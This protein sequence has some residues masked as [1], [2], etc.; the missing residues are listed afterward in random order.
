MLVQG[1]WAQGGDHE[2]GSLEAEAQGFVVAQWSYQVWSKHQ[3]ATERQQAATAGLAWQRWERLLAPASRKGE[4]ELSSHYRRPQPRPAPPRLPR[5]VLA[6]SALSSVAGWKTQQNDFKINY[7]PGQHPSIVLYEVRWSRGT[8]R[9]IWRTCSNNSTQ[10]AEVSCLENCFKTVPSVSCSI[11]WVLPTTHCGKCSRI[12][13]FLRVHPSVTLEICAAK[14]FKH[15][16]IHNQQ[17]LRNL[18]MNGVII[19]IMNLADYSY[20]WKRFVASQHGEDDYWPDSFASHIFLNLIELC[21]ILSVSR[22]LKKILS[23]K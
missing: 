4:R 2:L 15:L 13:E 10:H 11:T 18:A 8:W 22:H 23:E 7:L 16:D 14:M 1:C 19:R 9:R 6:P 5:A 3:A 12:L 17:G 21:H 20:W